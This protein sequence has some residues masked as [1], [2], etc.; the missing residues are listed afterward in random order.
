M[1]VIILAVLA[2]YASPVRTFITRTRQINQ[3]RSITEGINRQH[4]NLL[5]EREKLQNNDYIEQVARR[6]LGL[7]RP[8][9]QSFVVKDLSK[10]NKGAYLQNAVSKNEQSFLD[11]ISGWVG[12]ALQ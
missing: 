1:L 3:E 7:V 2:S 10:G 4:E 6:D 5:K 11:R 8:G 12:A 9:E